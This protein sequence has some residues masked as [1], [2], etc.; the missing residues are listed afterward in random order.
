MRL[1]GLVGMVGLV[2]VVLIVAAVAEARS[3]KFE[4][5]TKYRVAPHAACGYGM[6]YSTGS[7]PRRV[8]T[9][10]RPGL[11]ARSTSKWSAVVTWH[12]A[13]SAPTRCKTTM[14]AVSLGNY[15]QWLPTTKLVDPRGRYS[16]TVRLLVSHTEPPSDTVI[17]SS[18][19]PK[20]YTGRSSDS[21]VLIRH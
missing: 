6:L 12:I 1:R 11:S 8:P 21:G 10:G 2:A 19:G 17:A 15:A 3:T 20:H 14:L 18:F 5:P 9:P 4:K 7:S 13:R 16:G